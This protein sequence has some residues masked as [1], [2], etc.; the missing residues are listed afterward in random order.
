MLQVIRNNLRAEAK[1]K[2]EPIYEALGE[3]AEKAGIFVAFRCRDQNE[4]SKLMSC[5]SNS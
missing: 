2:C 1:E 5:F 3:C 4:A